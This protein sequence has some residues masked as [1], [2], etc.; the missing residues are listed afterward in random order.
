MAEAVRRQ[1]EQRLLSPRPA[2]GARFLHNKR[3]S[4]IRSAI[5]E[6]KGGANGDY[7]QCE[8][9]SGFGA[10]KSAGHG[11]GKKCRLPHWPLP[12]TG[13]VFSNRHRGSY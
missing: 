8:Y 11:K 6:S 4:T 7:P 2:S 3:A 13:L 5:L 10:G 12:V 9:Q 1:A